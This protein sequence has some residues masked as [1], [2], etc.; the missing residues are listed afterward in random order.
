MDRDGCLAWDAADPLGARRDLIALPDGVI[1]LDGNSLGPLHHRVAT[2]LREVI[3][4]EWGEGLVTSWNPS[5]SGPGWVGL[6]GRVAAG[7]APWIGADADEIAVA[8]STSVNLFKA[9]AAA[10]R[11]RPDR[12]VILTDDANFPTDVYVA[13]GLAELLGDREVRVVPTR[14]VADHLD[15]DVAVLTLTHVD[16]RTGRRHDAGALTRAA[17]DAG[18][19]AVWDLSHSTGALAVDLHAWDADLAVGCT[20]KYLDGGPGAPAFLYVA[21]RWH[22]RAS[23]PLQGWFGHERPFAFAERYEPAAGADRFLDGTPPVLSLAALEAALEL[24]VGISPVAAEAKARHLTDLFIARVDARLDGEV[25]VVTPRDP[26]DRGAQ[27]SLRHEH[28][29]AVM[30]ALI[31]RGV[32]GDHRPPDLL[33]FGF[34]PLVVRAVD[35]HDAVEVLAEVLRTCAW[36]T[37]QHRAPRTVI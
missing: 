26:S 23:T 7:I 32:V 8:D 19:L 28:A 37:D 2:R 25:E 3:A 10:C 36:D 11:L 1:Y 17:H 31:E 18:A 9:L 34:S 35:V 24:R 4:D 21:R 12:R 14:E 13:G 22:D 6:P 5:A 20:Y 30:S 15:D 33:R 29:A 27:V 16:Y